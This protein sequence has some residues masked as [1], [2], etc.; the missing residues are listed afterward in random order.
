[1]KRKFAAVVLGLTMAIA[2]VSAYAE[3][4]TEAT[5]LTE[6]ADSQADTEENT[7]AAEDTNR[8]FGIVTDVNEDGVTIE[9]E[10]ALTDG[11]LAD[12]TA[13]DSVDGLDASEAGE[14]DAEDS[15]SADDGDAEKLED[16]D[17]SA[18]SEDA[19]TDSATDSEDASADSAADSENAEA[20]S[21]SAS[22]NDT[23]DSEDAS[24][25]TEDS[26]DAKAGE[27]LEILVTDDTQIY[28]VAD[29][30]DNRVL[31]EE[32][33]ENSD[34]LSDLQ[35][36]E[37]SSIQE[38]DTVSALLDE[39]GNATVM[40]VMFG[41]DTEDESETSSELADE[42]SSPEATEDVSES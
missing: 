18:D 6:A 26:A 30:E 36:L 7:D 8:V 27:E 42:D 5:E 29:T 34:D 37:L 22:E 40:L 19:A 17:A 1:M 31:M 39:D 38:G 12:D 16:A 15:G 23:T 20:D 11:K 28:F 14:T 3:E 33:T 41:E 2:P 24:A 13:E 32:F 25:D 21:E 4:N 35:T 10:E 9:R